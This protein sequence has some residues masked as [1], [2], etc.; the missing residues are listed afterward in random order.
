MTSGGESTT[1]TAIR[2]SLTWSL[3]IRTDG[4]S[5]LSSVLKILDFADGKTMIR[6]RS[7]CRRGAHIKTFSCEQSLRHVHTLTDILSQIKSMIKLTLFSAGYG[8]HLCLLY[9]V[10]LSL[11]YKFYCW[12]YVERICGQGLYLCF[13]A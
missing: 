9:I 7:R 1:L 10:H 5:G 12:F 4:L 8:F 6:K 2:V 3:L 13:S 11:P